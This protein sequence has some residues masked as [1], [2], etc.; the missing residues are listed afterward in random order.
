M[1]KPLSMWAL[2]YSPGDAPG[3]YVLRRFEILPGGPE[4]TLD[5]IYGRRPEPLRL[6]MLKLGLHMIPRNPADHP[7]VVE[8]WV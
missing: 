6:H 2:F 5:A 1:P 4:P 8:C 3:Q 7:S